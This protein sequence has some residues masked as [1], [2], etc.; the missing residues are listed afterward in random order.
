MAVSAF[1]CRRRGAHPGIIL[2]PV[3][4]PIYALPPPIHP[5]FHPSGHPPIHLSIHPVIYPSFHLPARP[6]SIHPPTHLSIHPSIHPLIYPFAH[7][8]T[9]LPSHSSIHAPICF[10]GCS[11]KATQ[12]PLPPPFCWSLG[13]PDLQKSQNLA[14][15][16]LTE[17]ETEA[18]GSYPSL[19][20]S[21]V[22]M[23]VQT[24]LLERAESF[25][26]GFHKMER[27]YVCYI[28]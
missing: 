7:P 3:H 20:N 18:Q 27:E 15:L 17:R 26:I 21:R 28:H 5:A 1:H 6:S 10:S 12:C 2:T 22:G 23:R 14:D 16:Q 25:P 11:S 19:W 8:S 9:H 13:M 4:F 24:W